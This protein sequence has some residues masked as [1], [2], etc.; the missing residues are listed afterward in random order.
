MIPQ[1]YAIQAQIKANWI[2]IRMA[3]YLL[4]VVALFGGG[5]WL[6]YEYKSGKV[7]QEKNEQ[8]LD[9][10]AAKNR[11]IEKRNEV[12][13][14]L[15]EV[16]AE[17]DEFKRNLKPEVVYVTRKVNV[18]VEKPVY[19]ECVLPDSGVR[20]HDETVERLNDQRRSD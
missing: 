6:G 17:Y 2:A 8:L 16:S 14:E 12:Q 18:E 10:I 13:K 15:D 5:A 1:I 20:L 19:R 7:A 11:E 9:E 3:L 4:L